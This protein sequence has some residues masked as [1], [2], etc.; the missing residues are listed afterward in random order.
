MLFTGYFRRYEEKR[1]VSRDGKP[2]SPSR[3]Q[4][5]KD[6]VQWQRPG[7]RS[8]QRFSGKPESSFEQRRT[9]QASFTKHSNPVPPKGPDQV[10]TC[11][12]IAFIGQS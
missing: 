11:T 8:A 2:K 9:S 12:P 4:E 7:E 5:E 3:G 6:T 1:W 10:S